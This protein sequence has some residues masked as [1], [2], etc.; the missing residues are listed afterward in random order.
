MAS[1][2]RAGPPIR[3]LADRQVA[4]GLGVTSITVAVHHDRRL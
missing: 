1:S 3:V 4:V 2:G